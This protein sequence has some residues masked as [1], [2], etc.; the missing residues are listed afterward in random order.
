L[1]SKKL[2]NKYAIGFWNTGFLATVGGNSGRL[3]G[4]IA[5]TMASSDGKDHIENGVNVPSTIISLV[6][7]LLVIVSWYKLD[8]RLIQ[9]KK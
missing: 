5:V 9:A 2:P 1:L 6:T 7:T 3:F 4:N 8:Y